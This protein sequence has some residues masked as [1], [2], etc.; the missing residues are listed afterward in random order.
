M[1]LTSKQLIESIYGPP[2]AA[3]QKKLEDFR[4]KEIPKPDKPLTGSSELF[5]KLDLEAQYNLRYESLKSVGILEKLASGEKGII[6]LDRKEYPI[7]SLDQVKAKIAEQEQGLKTKIEQGFIKLIIVP[8]ALPL[9]TLKDK[10]GEALEKHYQDNKL[11]ATNGDK[12]ELDE[13]EPIWA[14]DQYDNADISGELVY[15]PEQFNQANHNGQT[16]AELLKTDLNNGWQIL[17]IEDLP[18]L[19]AS[20]QGQTISGRAQLEADQTPREYLAK[21]KTDPSYKNE[22]GL[23]PED[24]LTY[25]ISQLAEKNQAID[26]YQGQGKISYNLGA[27]FPASGCVPYGYWYRDDRQAFLSRCGSGYRASNRGVRAG[28]SVF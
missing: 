22:Q 9:D 17:L 4:K 13:N 21:L 28:V 1:P 19:P 20:G 10:Y 8:F 23:T 27:Y 11:T 14:W 25:A 7:P 18:D 2:P 16:K 15:Y 5:E 24:W 26:D 3:G 6:G 12:L